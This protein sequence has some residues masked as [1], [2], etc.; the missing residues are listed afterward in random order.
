MQDPPGGRSLRERWEAYHPTKT[1]AFWVAGGAIAATLLI[2]FGP[3]RWV[4][5]GT[6]Q[7]MAAEAARNAR[8]EL[9]AAVCV[10]EFMGAANTGARL[11]QIKTATWFE[12][13]DLVTEWATMPDEAQPSSVVASTCAAELAKLEA[14][15]PAAA[16]PAA[17]GSASA[18]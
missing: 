18:K 7:E 10:E 14:P 8:Q 6:A 15:G 13:D 16:K 1:H 4:T 5:S 9:A 3:G 12:R 2:G 11:E 17:P